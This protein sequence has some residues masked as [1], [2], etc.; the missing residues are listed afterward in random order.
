MESIPDN[1]KKLKGT[2]QK[3]RKAREYLPMGELIREVPPAPSY[4]NKRARKEWNNLLGQMIAAEVLESVY[5][6]QLEAYCDCI[7]F[8]DDCAKRIK[9]DGAIITMTN[10]AGHTNLVEHPAVK[11]SRQA[12]VLLNNIAKRFGFD[13]ASSM[14]G[15]GAPKK[16]KEESKHPFE[17]AINGTP[18]KLRVAR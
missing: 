11:M 10:K 3:A 4:F 2:F 17:E 7:G 15:I 14:K 6:P 12:Q 18:G 9:K 13:P 8:I 16:K 1:E 5:L